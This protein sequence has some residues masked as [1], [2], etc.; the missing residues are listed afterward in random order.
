[1]DYN[2]IGYP[3]CGSAA[4]WPPTDDG[5]RTATEVR[6]DPYYNT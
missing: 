1:M 2:V 3:V 4:T 6:P 5:D